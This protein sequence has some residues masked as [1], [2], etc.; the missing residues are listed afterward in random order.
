MITA[1]ATK[2]PGTF[3]SL[4]FVSGLDD[5]KGAAIVW[6]HGI[7]ERG[8][9]LML[10]AKYGLPAAISEGRL[11]CSADVFCP[12][13]EIDREWD[14]KRIAELM[15]H[16]RGQYA[17]SALLGFSLGALGVC[18]VLAE[19]GLQANLHIAI[20]PR[21]RQLPFV[22][23][24]STHLVSVS[25]EHDLWPASS[26]YYDQL[27]ALGAQV[28]EVVLPGEGHF[29]SETALTHP[30]AQRALGALGIQLTQLNEA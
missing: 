14:P 19:F 10:V 25:G 16:I 8:N 2:L 24:I 28:E 23:Q 21:T 27:R 17:R 9:D 15:T 20:A 7:G 6:L 3:N 5:T 11:K 22:R 30:T 29:I 1:I 13:L 26:E 4:K 18:E 12:Q